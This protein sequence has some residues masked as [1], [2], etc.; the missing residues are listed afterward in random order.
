MTKGQK[1][2]LLLGGGAL[3]YWWYTQQS[4]TCP[5]AGS[6]CNSPGLGTQLMAAVAGWQNVN[7]GPTWVPVLNQV[8]QQYGFPSNLLAAMAYQESSF[9]QNV[10]DGSTPSSAGALGLMQ[11]MPAYYTSVQVPVPFSAC[12][13]NNQI[14]QAAQTMQTNYAALNSWPLAIAAY[15]AGLS[16]VQGAGGIPQNGQTPN[17]VA[18]ILA[19]A[20]AANA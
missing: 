8:E 1:V 12:D 7:E 3:L 18:G 4:G 2:L 11:L 17:Y 19:N 9:L 13:T 6:G 16:A 15:N 5:I 10:I 14:Q 20:P